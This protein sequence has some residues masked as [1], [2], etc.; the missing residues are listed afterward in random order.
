M[1]LIAMYR[2]MIPLEDFMKTLREALE[3][4]GY[5]I[6][7]YEPHK[8]RII[9]I[10]GKRMVLGGVGLREF[11]LDFN[12]FEG[13]ECVHERKKLEKLLGE[14][15]IDLVKVQMK[16]PARVETWSVGD[17]VYVMGDIGLEVKG[18]KKTT[19]PCG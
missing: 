2:L 1:S 13:D 19:S 15:K 7:L 16:T 11:M 17:R 3:R 14:D 10:R 4:M 18:T 6:D 9:A 8:G 12:G 5:R